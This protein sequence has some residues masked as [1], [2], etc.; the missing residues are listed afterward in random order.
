M[1][2]KANWWFQQTHTHT[3]RE[4]EKEEIQNYANG[5]DFGVFC[6]CIF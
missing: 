6:F 2:W 3:H 1:N 5:D 4:R